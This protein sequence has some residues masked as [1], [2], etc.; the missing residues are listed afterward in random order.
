MKRPDG[1]GFYYA[2][3]VTWKWNGEGQLVEI[4]LFTPPDPEE[5]D[6]DYADEWEGDMVM[7]YC[8]DLEY[9]TRQSRFTDWR[10]IPVTGVAL[11]GGEA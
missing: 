9:C 11:F 6:P 10:K 5:P 7:V 3:G 1:N 8:D 4:K 2:T